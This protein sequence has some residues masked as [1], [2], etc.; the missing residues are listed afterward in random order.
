MIVVRRCPTCIF[1]AIF[2][3][4][5][6]QYDPL[7]LADVQGLPEGVALGQHFGNRSLRENSR[8]HRKVHKAAGRFHFANQSPPAQ[9]NRRRETLGELTRILSAP[10]LRR[11]KN[12]KSKVSNR[13][14]R[15][16]QRDL[17]RLR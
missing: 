6:L 5:V 14:F 2:G 15:N 9:G 7:P 1:R 12:R 8:R 3:R 4:R 10:R 17:F 11:R 13:I 16:R